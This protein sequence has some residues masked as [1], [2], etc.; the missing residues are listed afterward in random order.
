V[1]VC[2]CLE[3]SRHTMSVVVLVHLPLISYLIP[4][5]ELDDTDYSQGRKG[6]IG[7][8]EMFQCTQLVEFHLEG[9]CIPSVCIP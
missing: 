9:C 3:E 6:R 1:C 5:N 7:V 4:C 2:V 8:Q